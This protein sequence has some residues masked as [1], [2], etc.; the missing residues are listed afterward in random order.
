MMGE[1]ISAN[2][3]A[4][5]IKEIMAKGLAVVILV[6]WVAVLTYQNFNL[7]KKVDALQRQMWQMQNEVIKDN[8]KALYE[9]NLKNK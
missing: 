6:S 3:R 8:T 4:I 1:L 9:F 7:N 5:L 2:E